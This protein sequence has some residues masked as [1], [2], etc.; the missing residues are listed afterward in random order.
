MCFQ[1]ANPVNIKSGFRSTEVIVFDRNILC[2]V[3][4]LSFAVKDR[5]MPKP[6]DVPSTF[7]ATA[8]PTTPD[9]IDMPST[10]STAPICLLV[11]ANMHVLPL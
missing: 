3:E 5:P 11:V 4:F 6:I 7:M 9:Y 1:A 10:T 8:R 2:E